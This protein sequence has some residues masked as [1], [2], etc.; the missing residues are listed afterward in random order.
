MYNEL[1]PGRKLEKIKFIEGQIDNPIVSIITPYYNAGKY[2]EET[3][4]SIL[5]QTFPYFEWII[6]DDDSTKDEDK[7]KL[8][9][10]EKMDKRIRIFYKENEGPARARDYG[11]RQANK[12]SEYLLFLD[13]DDL[14]SSTYIE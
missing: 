10:I 5:N 1:R 3:A 8:K 6:V 9:Q 11:V 2:I 7:E 4:N 14:I 12:Y 13:A